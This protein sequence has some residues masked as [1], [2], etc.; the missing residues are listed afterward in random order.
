MID[1][2]VE[3]R[4]ALRRM[5]LAGFQGNQAEL[6]AALKKQGIAAAQPSISRDLR[7]LGAVKTDCGYVLREQDHVTPLEA[8]RSLLRDASSAGPNLV[9]IRCEPGAAS[10]VAR[11][12]EAEKHEGMIGSVAGDDTV[13]VAVSG[14]VPGRHLQARIQTLLGESIQ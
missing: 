13:M 14:K 9:L 3:R 6:R 8:L 12:L 2:T 7:A 5:L 4:D 1:Q 11:A 10:A